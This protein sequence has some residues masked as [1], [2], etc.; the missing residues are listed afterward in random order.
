MAKTK[1]AADASSY[2]QFKTMLRNKDYGRMYVLFGEESY[3]VERCCSTLK[4]KLVSGPAEDFN[5][6]RFTTENWDIEAFREAVEAIPMM[7]EYSLIEVVDVN[8]FSFGE[9]DRNL[10]AEIFSDIPEYCTLLFVYDTVPWK[11]DKRLKK[12]YSAMEPVCRQYEMAKQTERELIPWIRSLAADAGKTIE[13]KLCQYLILKTDGSMTILAAEM[14]KLVCYTDQPQITRFD[15]DEV[16]IPVMEAVVFDITTDIGRRDFDAALQKLKDLLRQENE[17]IS[18]NA[19]IG[20][21]LRQM[22]AAKVLA[23]HGKAYYDLQQMYGIWESAA[24]EV[25]GQA[26]G[27]RKKQLKESL[28]LCAETDLRMK[29]SASDN[30]ALLEEMVLRLGQLG[31]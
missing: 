4:K 8:F 9:S 30:A 20:R 27:Y 18:I 23:E 14:D 5:Y 2:Q 29:S 25:Y 19:V 26:R 12:L 3:L 11:P 22:Y 21:H 1:K 31:G 24:R 7:S 13:D 15:I 10:M 16:V 6:H 17:P 28:R